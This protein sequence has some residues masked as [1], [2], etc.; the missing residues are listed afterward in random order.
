MCASGRDHP[1]GGELT[2]GDIFGARRVQHAQEVG[3]QQ[4][5]LWHS[6]CANL[7]PASLD[8]LIAQACECSL[9]PSR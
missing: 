8:L 6:Y 9:L 1:G 3:V 5:A 4:R 7:C 2:L